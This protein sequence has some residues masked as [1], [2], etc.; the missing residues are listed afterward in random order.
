[1]RVNEKYFKVNETA[2]YRVEVLQNGEI[3]EVDNEGL[4]IFLYN[5][6]NGYTGIMPK[7]LE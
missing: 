3:L 2:V 4:T 7:Y 1:M 5:M 6:Q